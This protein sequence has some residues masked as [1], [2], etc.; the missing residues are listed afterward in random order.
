ML[1][2]LPAGCYYCCC[3]PLLLRGHAYAFAF[4][5]PPTPV[6]T[7]CS[8]AGPL[9]PCSCSATTSDEGSQGDEASLSL[10]KQLDN[11][12]KDDGSQALLDNILND[13][14]SQALLKNLSDAAERVAAA[15]RELEDLEKR[16]QM[17]SIWK[18]RL[19]NVDS[20]ESLVAD[21]QREVFAAE[22]NVEKAER[23]LVKARAGSSVWNIS[24]KWE[25]EGI[26]QDTERIESGKAAT[27]SAFVGTLA[28]LPWSTAAL[29]NVG[30]ELIV[31]AGVVFTSCALFGVTYRYAVRHDIG[32]TQLRAGCASAFALV[33]GLG[34]IDATNVFVGLPEGA[35]QKLFHGSLFA[36]ESFIIFGFAAIALDFCFRQGLISPFP[37]MQE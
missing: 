24:K 29:G 25:L 15:R 4:A 35:T 18:S 37:S 23:A 36:G 28:S 30:V 22:V 9:P 6:S 19:E 27:V 11:I 3:G 10:D 26:D 2:A 17:T 34:Q 16:E 33:R 13:D 14:E 12:L 7:R 32:N 5:L 20:A 1:S 8:H 31:S 21:C